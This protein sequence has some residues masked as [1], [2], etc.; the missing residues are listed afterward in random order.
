MKTGRHGNDYPRG[1]SSDGRTFMV[2]KNGLA[3]RFAYGDRHP[4]FRP[5][6]ISRFALAIAMAVRL[7]RLPLQFLNSIFRKQNVE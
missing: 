2:K 1:K 3:Y 6:Q 4:F 7:L 5:P